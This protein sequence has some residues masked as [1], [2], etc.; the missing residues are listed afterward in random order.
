MRAY[1]IAI[2]LLSLALLAAAL[3]AEP[4]TIGSASITAELEWDVGFADRLPGE[5]TVQAF[6]L[7]EEPYQHVES[8]DC[9][10]V[11]S[12]ETDQFGNSVLKFTFSPA[13]STEFM[14]ATARLSVGYEKG[15]REALSGEGDKFLLE[16][17]YVK[18]TEEIKT[19]AEAVAGGGTDFEKA[20]KLAEWAHNNLKYEGL[21]YRDVILDSSQAYAVR[22]GKCSEFSHLLIAMLRSIGIPAKFTAGF[23]FSG[24][25][26]GP[27]AWAE[28]LVDG[29]WVPA[30]P[31][32]N[33]FGLLGAGHI[34]FAEGADQ[35]GIKEQISTKGAGV[36]ASTLSL[37]RNAAITFVSRGNFSQPISLSLEAN[38]GTV[39][40][41]SLETVR[42]HVKNLGGETAVPLSINM[43][44][45]VKIASDRDRLIYLGQGGEETVEWN[46]VFPAKLEEG[47]IYNYTVEVTTIGKKAVA[48]ITAKK[49]GASNLQE[50]LEI[51]D[52]RSTQSDQSVTLFVV[53]KNSGSVAIPSVALSA[54]LAGAEEHRTFSLAAGE[55]KELQLVFQ[56][57]DGTAAEGVIKVTVNGK[58]LAQPFVINLIQQQ[59][60]PERAFI[61][62]ALGGNEIKLSLEQALFIAGTAIVL[63][64]FLAILFHKPKKPHETG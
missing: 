16:T 26:W 62:L 59:P 52:L 1:P 49:G 21:G 55:E 12:K 51:K 43:P 50:S 58:E 17:K 9:N 53:L 57:P 7:A 22:S 35:D 20:V 2:I 30:D 32:F 36:A 19:K 15:F 41:G 48:Y 10:R 4:K 6:A 42:A 60:E 61:S 46:V 18:I 24:S 47:S 8:I 38:N 39:G 37:K 63:I 33:E 3:E 5:V 25:E 27:H 44:Q 56:K 31:T 45:E 11:C 54:S 29:K 40:E 28:A 14:K 23:V 64:A 34:K 13:S